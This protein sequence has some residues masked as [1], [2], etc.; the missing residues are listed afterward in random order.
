MV[1]SPSES[2]ASQPGSP[3]EPV[4]PDV[5][6]SRSLSGMPYHTAS[7]PMLS[8]IPVSSTPETEILTR[9]ASP[10]P[11]FVDEL[12]ELM[13]ERAGLTSVSEFE[14]QLTA[15]LD[16]GLLKAEIEV[17][18]KDLT[19]IQEKYQQRRKAQSS[20]EETV[21]I[22]TKIKIQQQQLK[23]LKD[24]L[25]TA[26]TEFNQGVCEHRV[27][28]STLLSAFSAIRQYQ[29]AEL[30]QT[31]CSLTDARAEIQSLKLQLETEK[32][33]HQE[34]MQGQA[35]TFEEQIEHLKTDQQS[36]AH[37]LEQTLTA[38][39]EDA[40]KIQEENLRL[41]A[42]ITELSESN[43]LLTEQPP[44][45]EE[46][47][48]QEQPGA[49]GLITE[50]LSYRAESS[51]SPTTSFSFDFSSG[52]DGSEHKA[53]STA[54]GFVLAGGIS[55]RH[56]SPAG[57]HTVASLPSD[58]LANPP[59]NIGQVFAYARSLGIPQHFVALGYPIKNDSQGEPVT[60]H[61]MDD[62]G[63]PENFLPE[64]ERMILKAIRNQLMPANKSS[65]TALQQEGVNNIW[66]Q[67]CLLEFFL[68][69]KLLQNWLVLPH[70]KVTGKLFA[71]KTKGKSKLF[72][73]TENAQ[74]AQWRIDQ[75]KFIKQKKYKSD[76]WPMDWLV[77]LAQALR[78]N[79]D[80]KLAQLAGCWAD[81]SI[82]ATIANM[83]KQ[84]QALYQ[85]NTDRFN[86]RKLEPE[87]SFEAEST[88]SRK[89]GATGK[90]KGPVTKRKKYG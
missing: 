17:L 37:E 41:L 1:P 34:A 56:S 47:A 90:G 78:E 23:E 68:F 12:P 62:L 5:S 13:E 8:S 89:R 77:K 43:R 10:L 85:S 80:D 26:T 57:S 83:A 87:V 36:R 11:T 20:R 21:Q 29:E 55:T 14:Q 9:A 74:I 18:R 22:L 63:D 42:R 86:W 30:E 40:E 28:Y 24:S 3:Q 15:R 7:D 45:Q 52:S 69:V 88:P 81:F 44:V 6:L 50:P 48:E 67:A 82:Q 25:Q 31:N 72:N 71:L 60:I 70:G 84:E 73:A 65:Y 16:Q 32:K 54:V 38:R 39:I 2:V 64:T 27:Q 19:S 4:S 35:Q 79:P 33:R 61:S 66:S 49:S 46:S 75:E 59:A 58:P 53:S 51:F 76:F